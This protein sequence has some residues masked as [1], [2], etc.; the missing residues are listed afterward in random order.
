MALVLKIVQ[1]TAANVFRCRRVKESADVYPGQVHATCVVGKASIEWRTTQM[2][3]NQL[4]GLPHL[5]YVSS[6]RTSYEYLQSQKRA[7]VLKHLLPLGS[8]TGWQEKKMDAT[9]QSLGDSRDLEE[10]IGC[11]LQIMDTSF[12]TPPSESDLVTPSQVQRPLLQ[13]Q[14]PK[15]KQVGA[16]MTVQ[17]NGCTSC[18]KLGEVIDLM[19]RLDANRASGTQQQ[20]EKA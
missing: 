15:H 14:Q 3:V 1:E 12:M 7:R 10:E 16:Q 2:D 17:E 5:S 13:P 18:S 19:E 6:L 20:Q 11:V 9:R 8:L 4:I